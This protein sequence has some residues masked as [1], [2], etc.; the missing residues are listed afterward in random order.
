RVA[1]R[2]AVDPRGAPGADDRLQRLLDPPRPTV[3]V[4]PQFRRALDASLAVRD[5]LRKRIE[6]QAD[7]VPQGSQ[8]AALSVD[9][10]PARFV[11]REDDELA[12]TDDLR[13]AR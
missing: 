2:A 5:R 7:G 3:D 9:R 12:G 8:R 10:R 1:P 6:H 13:P 4:E 11:A